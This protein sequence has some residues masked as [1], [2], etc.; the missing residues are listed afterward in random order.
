M[1]GTTKDTNFQPVENSSGVVQKKPRETGID[2]FWEC[3]LEAAFFNT[4]DARPFTGF[5]A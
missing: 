4:R 3:P 1:N 5:A 2:R